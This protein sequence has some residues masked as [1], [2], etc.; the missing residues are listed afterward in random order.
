M[1]AVQG[2]NLCSY[3]KKRRKL[4]EHD[5]RIIFSQ[6]VN[7]L[8]YLH[9]SNICHR[10]LKLENILLDTEQNVKLIDF[11]FSVY[12]KDPSRKL[13]VYCGTPSYMA[14]EIV[15]C[16]EYVGFPVDIW[17]LG[18]LLFAML[19]GHFPFAAESYSELYKKIIKGRFRLPDSLSDTVKHLLSSM[20]TKDVTG[21]FTI[22][23]VR[24]HAWTTLGI[25]AIPRGLDTSILIH[26]DAKKEMALEKVVRRVVQFG[27]DKV[28]LQQ[29]IENK[30]KN[31]C[32]TTFYL[33]KRAYYRDA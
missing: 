10:D 12:V 1:E 21:R 9:S 14:P 15:L 24:N 5:A 7:G 25:A 16:K 17:S 23:Q 28:D 20:L 18:V 13:K 3:L 22:N 32:T 27:F 2:N 29:M 31:H 6:V 19:C 26:P 4:S 11:G 30:A 33:S 8:Q